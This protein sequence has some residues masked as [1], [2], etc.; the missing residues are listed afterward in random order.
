MDTGKDWAQL[1]IRPDPAL[2]VRVLMEF[3]A[4]T[5]EELEQWE[6]EAN[7]EGEISR[8]SSVVTGGSEKGMNEEGIRNR[9][10]CDSGMVIEVAAVVFKQVG[11]GR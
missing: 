5:P 8:W 9:H 6:E 3:Q 4:A 11:G 7:L 10:L 1:Q 2:T